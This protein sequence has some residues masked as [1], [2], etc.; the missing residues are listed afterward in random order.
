MAESSAAAPLPLE[1]A[2]EPTSPPPGAE[3][4]AHG[5]E[6]V[7]EGSDDNVSP[8]GD[9]GGFPATRASFGQDLEPFGGLLKDSSEQLGGVLPGGGATAE[10]G[11]EASGR[12]GPRHVG[13]VSLTSSGMDFEF[14]QAGLQP[15]ETADLFGLLPPLTGEESAT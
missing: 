5:A 10:G 2:F 11:S 8:E 15:R 12:S 4:G 1:G 7:H 13:R 14:A 3:R 9:P 6:Q